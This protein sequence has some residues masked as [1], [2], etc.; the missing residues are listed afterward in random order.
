MRGRPPRPRAGARRHDDHLRRV[1]RRATTSSIPVGHVEAGLRTGNLYSPWPEE[2]NRKL[3]ERAGRPALRPDRGVAREPARRGRDPR[4][5]CI[6]TGNTVIDALLAVVAR[7][8]GDARAARRSRRP[9]SASS[10]RAGAWCS[11]PA[12]AA[13]ASATA[14]SASARRSPP[15]PGATPTLEFV[16]PV[17]LNPNVQRAG[18]AGSSAG[19]A[20]VHLIEPLDYLPFVYLMNRGAPD[21]HRLRRGAGGGALARQAGA[22]HARHHR[23][24]RGGRRRHGAPGRHRRGRRSWQGSTACSTTRRNTKG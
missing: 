18:A 2:A 15:P 22:R 9:A 5:R 20:N 17:H 23:A 8:E 4:A 16:Y 13:R 11:S 24:A 10:R 7:I 1:A 21:P 6:V 19:I 3:T 14:S 12:T